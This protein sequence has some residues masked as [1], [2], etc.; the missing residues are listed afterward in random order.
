MATKY[1]PKPID[2][3]LK[4]IEQAA[5]RNGDVIEDNA[6][7]MFICEKVTDMDFGKEPSDK[8]KEQCAE[9]LRNLFSGY[10]LNYTYHLHKCVGA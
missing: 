7:Y 1:Q 2:K 10:G 3:M 4:L 6:M 5:D 8:D 9:Y